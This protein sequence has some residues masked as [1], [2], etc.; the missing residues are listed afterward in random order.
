M[1]CALFF[2]NPRNQNQRNLSM[3]TL[4]DHLCKNVIFYDISILITKPM[5]N[6]QLIINGHFFFL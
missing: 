5:K 4:L 6:Y 3:R 2:L 1:D